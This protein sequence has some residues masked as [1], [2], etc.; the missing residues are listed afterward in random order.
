VLPTLL[1]VIEDSMLCFRPFL[2][3]FNVALKYLRLSTCFPCKSLSQIFQK[4]FHRRLAR[5]SWSCMIQRTDSDERTLVTTSNPLI[6]L[7]SIAKLLDT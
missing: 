7:E 3:L 2:L 4:K 6:Q 5:E 1:G